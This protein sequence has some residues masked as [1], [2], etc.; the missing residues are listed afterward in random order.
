MDIKVVPL[1]E[2]NHSMSYKTEGMDLKTGH[3]AGNRV[4]QVA[5]VQEAVNRSFS[6]YI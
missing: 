2:M 6:H 3:F 4:L 5:H 1:L